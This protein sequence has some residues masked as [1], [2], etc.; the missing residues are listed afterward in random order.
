MEWH[1]CIS[2]CFIPRPAPQP[3]HPP[4]LT[5]VGSLRHPLPAL[6]GSEDLTGQKLTSIGMRIIEMQ[7]GHLCPKHL[8]PLRCSHSPEELHA[9]TVF[10]LTWQAGISSGLACRTRSQGQDTH[11][12]WEV[13]WSWREDVMVITTLWRSSKDC[14]GSTRGW[15]AANSPTNSTHPIRR[16]LGQSLA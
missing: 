16:A 7:P 3:L 14:S 4:D 2:G 1:F 9:R 13:E 11:S 15:Q 12:E 10:R 5:R 6:S 8:P